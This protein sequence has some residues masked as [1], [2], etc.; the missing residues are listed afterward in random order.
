MFSDGANMMP[1]LLCGSIALDWETVA[2]RRVGNEEERGERAEGSASGDR[3]RLPTGST[4][5][6]LV[7][8]RPVRTRPFATPALPYMAYD[9]IGT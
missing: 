4:P 3:P 7:R 9:N 8:R 1:R 6:G 5:S 2:L